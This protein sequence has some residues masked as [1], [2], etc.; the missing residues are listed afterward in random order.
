MDVAE[1]CAAGALKTELT[2]KLAAEVLAEVLAEVS[3]AHGLTP[4]GFAHV[5]EDIRQATF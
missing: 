4:H 5:P 2:A 3:A 1:A